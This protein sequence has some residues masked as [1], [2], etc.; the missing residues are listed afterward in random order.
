MHYKY[1]C[2]YTYIY[3]KSKDPTQELNSLIQSI[4]RLTFTRDFA[5]TFHTIHALGALDFLEK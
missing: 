1:I 3:A 2:T 4:N 5:I